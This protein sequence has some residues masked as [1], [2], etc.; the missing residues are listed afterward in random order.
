[1][2]E[3]IIT[4]DKGI[5]RVEVVDASTSTR[6]ITNLSEEDAMEDPVLTAIVNHVKRQVQ[7]SQEN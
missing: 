5:I 1:M 3:Q 2:Q 6:D 7:Q 4:Y